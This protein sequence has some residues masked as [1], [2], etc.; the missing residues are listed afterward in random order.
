M[1]IKPSDF[2]EFLITQGINKV[3]FIILSSANSCFLNLF[4]KLLELQL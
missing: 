3:F 2:P 1:V 4:Y